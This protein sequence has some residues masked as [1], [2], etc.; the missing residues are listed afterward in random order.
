MFKFH[1]RK[2]LTDMP[3]I[4]PP[5]DSQDALVDGIAQALA[6]DGTL[7][8]EGGTHFTRPGVNKHIAVGASG[9]RIA[10]PSLLPAPSSA[11]TAVTPAVIRRP[12][13]ALSVSAPDF[14]YG[15]FF[16][17]TGPTP[18]EI[19][20]ATWK[21]FTDATTGDKFEFA[22][23]MRG[24]IE[25]SR[26]L[27]DCNMQNQGAESMP[28]HAAEHSAM[29]GFGGFRYSVPHPGTPRFMYVGFDTVA[30]DHLRFINGGFADDFW[31]AYAGGA[32][33]P[34]I[35]QV[36]IT[37]VS[38]GPRVDR[39]RATL[40]FSGLAQ[41]ITIADANIQSLNAEQDHSWK[42]APRRDELFSKSIWSLQRIVAD[43]MNFAMFG[44]V[45]TMEASDLFAG[46][47][48]DISYAGGTI[49]NSH[50]Q[51]AQGEDGRFF[52]LDGMHFD[53][54]HWRLPVDNSGTVGGITLACRFNDTC[55]ATFTKNTF[56][57]DKASRGQLINSTY[58]SGETGNNVALTFSNCTF[59]RLFGVPIFPD[60]A[61]AR[62]NE[63]G[64][65]KFDAAD[66]GNRPLDRALPKSRNRDVIL[67]V[68]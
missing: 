54:V 18:D 16:I 31:M 64:T 59:D 67:I 22:V 6:G 7:L 58:S 43:T 46:S 68:R 20:Q 52:L 8:L 35:N 14:N 29:L 39:H 42:E 62:V 45:M 37:N 30:V 44:K 51:V 48:F 53:G 25:I 49:A 27:I 17:P 55:Q 15:L 56:A 19:A 32:F 26:L 4:L 57:A 34:H 36:S 66:I 33:H 28:A 63:R 1:A 47:M 61:V 24:S 10:G 9:L 21:P 12:D 5:S 23:V 2:G 65:W 41:R 13:H 38:S 40:S 3:I 50:L 11:V 60:T